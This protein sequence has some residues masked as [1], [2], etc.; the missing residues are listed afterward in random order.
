MTKGGDA[1]LHVATVLFLKILAVEKD[2][3]RGSI[4]LLT[5]SI[6]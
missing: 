1:P 3:E 4:P 5:A 2:F 6:Q